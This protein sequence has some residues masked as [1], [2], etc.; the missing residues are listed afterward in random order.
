[1]DV[2]KRKET[3]NARGTE[4]FSTS[5]AREGALI[6]FS[7]EKSGESF[8]GL[9]STALIFCYPDNSGGQAK[10]KGNEGKK[11]HIF[12]MKLKHIAQ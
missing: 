12:P 4:K 10:S 8:L 2:M 7:P 5:N 1:M 6:S 3:P 9:F 11:N